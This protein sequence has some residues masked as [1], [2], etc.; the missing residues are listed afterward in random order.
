M[1]GSFWRRFFGPE[2][3]GSAEASGFKFPISIAVPKKTTKT[4]VK[5]VQIIIYLDCEWFYTLPSLFHLETL[6]YTSITCVFNLRVSCKWINHLVVSPK[7]GSKMAP[8][9]GPS[10]FFSI[11][12]KPWK[13]GKLYSFLP[14]LPRDTLCLHFPEKNNFFKHEDLKR[15]GCHAANSTFTTISYHTQ[16]TWNGCTG[17]MQGQ[18]QSWPAHPPTNLC[19]W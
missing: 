19:K 3:P 16:S 10:W 18:N 9:L 6:K 2:E 7:N 4:F 11:Y 14:H 8:W 13:T 5:S 12:A 15:H 1:F 17:P